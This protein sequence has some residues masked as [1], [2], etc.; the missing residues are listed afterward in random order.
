MKNLQLTFTLLFTFAISF[1]LN[2]QLPQVT[3]SGE[4]T[5]NT[6]WTND[7]IYILNGFVYVEDGADL[8]IEAG[9]IIRGQNDTKGTLIITRGS[10]LFANGTVDQ[11]IVFTSNQP[12]GS[13]NYG[14]WGGIILLG[15][16]PI[17]VP[18]GTAIIEGGVDT[19][20]G[21][22]VY[23]GDNASDNS[24]SLTYVRIEYP[25]I[26]FLPGSE[27][28]GLTCGGVGNGT[29]IDYVMV[30]RS[31]D[32]GIECF[33][34]TVNLSHIILY[35]SFDDNF[36]TDFGYSG[37]VQFGVAKVDPAIADVSG[38]TGFESDNDGTGSTNTPQT[39]PTYSNIT[40]IGPIENPGDVINALFTRGA[41]LRRN[42]STDIFNSVIVGYPRG[43]MIDGALSEASA[44]ANELKIQNTVLAGNTTSFEVALGSTFDINA[45]FNTPAYGNTIFD[46][47]GDILLT[48][49]YSNTSPNFM[50]LDGSPLLSG[51]SFAAPEL[52][53]LTTVAYKGAFGTINWTKCWANWD[54]QFTDYD[55]ELGTVALAS[56]DFGYSNSD[57]TVNFTNTSSNALSYAWD[58]G[59]ETTT[60]DVSTDP[61]PSYT[62]PGL[63]VYDAKLVATG[64]CD[65]IDSTTKTIDIS[66]GVVNI[67]A[68]KNIA[69]FPNPATSVLNLSIN[70]FET[71]DA[72]LQLFDMTGKMVY[73]NL[74]QHFNSGNNTIQINVQNLVEGIY[75]VN[76]I[77]NEET[78]SIK[79]LV[80]HN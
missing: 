15:Y 68:I 35:N 62:Y 47:T 79:V 16:A 12:Q 58:F 33:G 25:G 14:D 71:F 61:N 65:D 77:S 27:I 75:F 5:A 23:G 59:D 66:V 38:S 45:W 69:I 29:V 78:Q 48:D 54:P 34:G 44:T 30:S 6:T 73:Q 19:P 42:T 4:I 9:T 24:G 72:D 67:E 56:A 40:V 8:T 21:D 17:N 1:T 28:N 53:G 3:V 37:K 55:N 64:T 76:L 52:A 43:I 11:P 32:D 41:H 46:N 10:K 57:L 18:G 60:D 51:A 20:E 63:G 80:A 7:N 22:G 74:Q 70:A 39:N 31:G 26:A 50:P 13:R 2:A 36:D 49:P